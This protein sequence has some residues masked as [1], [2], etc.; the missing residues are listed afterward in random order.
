[1][2]IAIRGVILA[3]GLLLMPGLVFAS[4][5]DCA[6]KVS[7][8]CG[9]TPN[10]AFDKTGKLWVVFERQ[11]HLYI[12]HSDDLGHSFSEA[13]A[14]NSMP[15]SIYT[16]GENRPKLA[17]GSDGELFVSWTRKTPGRHTGEIRFSRSLN[18]GESFSVPLTVN[19]DGLQT[20]HRFDSLYVTESGK[21]FLAWLDKRDQVKQQEQGQAYKGAALY[22][23]VSEDGGASFS[24]N[25]N[26]AN[27]SCEC[28]RIAIA[29][30][31]PDEVVVLWRQIYETT[32]RDHAI[33]ILG[34]KGRS[35][36]AR[37]TVDDWQIEACPHHGPDIASSIDGKS[38]HMVWFTNGS[39]RKGLYYDRFVLENG[40]PGKPMS[41]DDR[42]GAGHPQVVV[43]KN[44]VFLLWKYFDGRATELRLMHSADAGDSWGEPVTILTATATSDHPQ[45]LQHGNKVY[46]GWHSHEEGYRLV[47]VN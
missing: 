7:P 44:S 43:A 31:G 35:M 8:A 24:K 46:A 25:I 33:A 15:E 29:G 27:H 10:A 42:P 3:I 19:D 41:I 21:V 13:V 2:K 37:G 20:S 16:N 26:V 47:P 17:F 23:A 32:T 14:V 36:V 28:C 6:G 34:A 18:G 45:L 11:Q 12:S 30:H 4:V 5:Q 38:Y 40:K 1:M 22:Y 39:L 9:N